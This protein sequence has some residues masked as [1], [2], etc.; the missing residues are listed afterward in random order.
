MLT[1]HKFQKSDSLEALTLLLNRA[2]AELGAIGL[3][4]TAVDQAPEVTAQRINGGECFL[5]RWN[6]E[7]VG[8]V[9][10]KPTDEN[11]EC[12]YFRRP[13]VATL[14]QFGVDPDFRGKGIGIQLIRTCEQW[15]KAHKYKEL[16]LDTAQAAT[17]LVA[18]YGRL[19]YLPVGQVQWPGK[20]YE[21][22]VLSK[23]LIDA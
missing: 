3:N 21:S 16:A 22:I 14:R 5:A 15:A 10:V 7:L 23:S 20:V 1:I 8:S 6:G 17:H 12:A 11:S 18:L 2:Y 4:Y 9:L 19:G 13:G